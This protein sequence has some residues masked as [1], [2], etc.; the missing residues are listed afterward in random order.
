MKIVPYESSSCQRPENL[1]FQQLFLNEQGSSQDLCVG[2]VPE[3]HAHTYLNQFLHSSAQDCESGTAYCWMT[4]LPLDGC[5]VEDS[6][7]YG[8]NQ[9]PCFDD[10]MDPSCAWHCKQ[11]TT[12]LGTSESPESESPA[13]TTSGTTKSPESELFCAGATDMLMEGFKTT[14]KV[15]NTTNFCIILFSKKWTLSSSWK[16]AAGSIGVFL[17]GF[18]IE[19]NVA[20]RRKVLTTLGSTGRVQ[21]A[22]RL[23]VTGLMYFV[24]LSLAYL[25]MLVAM[26]Y[27]VELFLCVIV[28]L[29]LGHM[30]FNSNL[31]VGETIDP[32]CASETPEN[33][34]QA[35]SEQEAKT[36]PCESLPTYY[37][38]TEKQ[39]KSQCCSN[40]GDNKRAN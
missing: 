27:S 38:Y 13:T 21:K 33:M 4:C 18:L 9:T 1:T 3:G 8:N 29:T 10:S 25:A 15:G 17:L 35:K 20:L 11:T 34:H 12:T 28:G 36:I 37:G 5:S 40:F 24:N 14:K 22:M 32:C 23:V 6:E 19:G 31:P 7:C 16:F 26:T 39:I 30:V 2:S